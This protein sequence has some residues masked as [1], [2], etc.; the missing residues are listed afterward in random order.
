MPSGDFPPYALK[1]DF[2]L[3][4]A[5][6]SYAV[7]DFLLDGR[8]IS[9]DGTAI[10][11]ERTTGSATFDLVR[12]GL[13]G[14]SAFIRICP[15][16]LIACHD[17]D[18]LLIFN[19]SSPAGGSRIPFSSGYDAEWADDNLLLVTIPTRVVAVDVRTNQVVPVVDGIRGAPAGVTLDS[20]GNLYTGNGLDTNPDLTSVTGTV[21]FFPAADWR[22]ALQRRM[23]LN[24]EETGTPIAE[25]L[26]AAYLGFDTYGHLHVS[27]SN[28]AGADQG[29]AALIE[30]NAVTSAIQGGPIITDASPAD[31]LYRFDPDNSAQK[32]YFIN[33]N[34]AT[35]ELY[36]KDFNKQ[37]VFVYG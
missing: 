15:S 16:E 36:L 23:P 21:K 37:K 17:G 4:G 22:Q 8:V 7:F 30:A 32:F 1:R 14:Y 35:A 29:F 19:T 13:K 33:D 24:F 20:Q 2:Q 11:L 26:S 18:Q 27:G 3:P 25:V 10:S 12:V 9:S 6:D 31:V 34:A 28:P 5:D